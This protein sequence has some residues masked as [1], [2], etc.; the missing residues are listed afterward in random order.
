MN[1]RAKSK[2]LNNS[3][4]QRRLKRHKVCKR[5]G[6]TDIITKDY[7]TNSC[8]I[9]KFGL[10]LHHL[11]SNFYSY[12]FFLGH[13]RCETKCFLFLYSFWSLVP[14]LYMCKRNRL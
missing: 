1:H 5:N 6:A 3:Q 11:K 14:S 13:L 10:I 8:M 7:S 2:D 9:K 12:Y 4:R